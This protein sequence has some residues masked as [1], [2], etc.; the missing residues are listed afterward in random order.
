MRIYGNGPGEASVRRPGHVYAELVG[1]LL[2]VQFL[3]VTGWSAQQLVDG[4][5][6]ICET[7]MYGAGAAITRGW[8]AGRGGCTG[9]ATVPGRGRSLRIRRAAG[10]W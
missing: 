5:L 8:R 3:D 6:L 9:R 7:G 2:D 1:G 4:A 10:A